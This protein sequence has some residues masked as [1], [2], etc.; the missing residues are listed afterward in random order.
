MNRQSRS[1]GCGSLA[2][3]RKV[4]RG[5]VRRRELAAVAERAFLEGGF[6]ATTMQAIAERAGASKETFYRHFANKERL[7]AEIVRARSARI[8]GPDRDAPTGAPAIVLAELGERA[9]ETLFDR[10]SVALFRVVVAEAPRSPELG[11]IFYDQGPGRVLRQLARYL[12]WADA[13]ALL[14]CDEP[15]KAAELLLGAML[16]PFHLRRVTAPD[17]APPDAPARRAHVGAAIAMFL[18][19]YGPPGSG[20]AGA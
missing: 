18:A 11:A 15:D 9:L 14:R 20:P 2:P 8:L 3:A 6:A 16:G 13:T 19:R 7:F 4:P 10:E 12:R 5:G 1:A 17:A